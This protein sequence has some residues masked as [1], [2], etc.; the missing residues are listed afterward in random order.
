MKTINSGEEAMLCHI[1]QQYFTLKLN[2]EF[3]L[4]REHGI[5][6]TDIL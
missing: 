6:Y 1:L 3:Q 5:P 2:G 4:Q